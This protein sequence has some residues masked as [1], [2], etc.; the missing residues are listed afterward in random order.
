M[1]RVATEIPETYETITRPASLDVIRQIGKLLGLPKETAI[2]YPGMSDAAAQTGSTLNY[3]GEP[4]SFPY[5]GKLKIEASEAYVE[6]RVLT[7]SVYRHENKPIFVD[8]DLGVRLYPVYSATEMTL[9][10]TYRAANRTMAERFRDDIKM[11]TS[12]LRRENLHE[13]T[14]SYG[15]PIPYL[16]LLQ[17][18]WTMRE[19]QAGYGDTFSKWV[20]DHVDQRLTNVTTLVGTEQQL[21]MPEHQVCAL[22][23]F[24]FNVAPEPG[25]KESDGGTV[26]VSF[27][28]HMIYDKVIGCVVEYPLVVH[29]QIISDAWHGVRNASGNLPSDPAARKRNPS[30]SRKNFDYFTNLYPCPCASQIDGVRY[31]PFDDWIPDH[32]L[33]DTSS[34]YTTIVQVD[35]NDTGDVL[36][37]QQLVDW[38][39]DHNVLDFLKTEA[40]YLTTYGS[41]IVHLQLYIDG[42][43]IEDGKL[44]VDPYLNV[45]YAPGMDLRTRFHFRMSLVN[46]LYILSRDAIERFRSSGCAALKIMM[47]LQQKLGNRAIVPKLKAGK[48]IPYKE[49]MDIAQTINSLKTPFHTG[50]EYAMLTV[51]NFIIAAH[52]SSDYADHATQTVGRG[53]DGSGTGSGNG[54]S[55]PGCGGGLEVPAGCVSTDV[56]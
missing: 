1:P 12:M 42:T 28:Y 33:P 23:W 36:N 10:I 40:Q 37:L 2:F 52:R 25:T 22:G 51:G 43:P 19:A 5:Y 17:E 13:L 35:P 49:L 15:L 44:S 18:I 7:D 56:C 24:D 11:R 46:D 47:T 27:E 32:V 38:D 41:S 6:D 45:R 55:V 50:T 54:H 34:L 8:A 31:P 48:Y 14:Y 39:I 21:V 16:Y 3:D 53:G 30:L 26:A 29:N 4:S 20:M 9:S